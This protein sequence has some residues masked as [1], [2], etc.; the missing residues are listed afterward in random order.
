MQRI[1]FFFLF[2]FLFLACRQVYQE[3]QGTIFRTTY[4]VK[5]Q[6]DTSLI[7]KI[8]AEL[9]AFD[10]SLNPFNPNSLLARVNRNEEVEIDQWFTI[11]FN[12][13]MEVS[14]Q[15]N[16]LF[17]VTAAPLINLWGFG[18][19]SYDEISPEIIDSIKTFVGF[20]KVRLEG[21]SVVK[22]D[23]RIMLN[24]S[25]IAKG[26]ACDVIAK[27]FEREGVKNYLVDIGGEIAAKGKNASGTCWKIGINEPEDEVT[28][29]R[30]AYKEIVLLCGKNGLA[31]SGN[32]R[33]YYIK[34]GKKFAHT[35]N[36]ITGYPVAQNI[37]STTIIAPDCMTADAYATAFMVMGID[38]ACSMAAQIPQIE[39]YIIYVEEDDSIGI[40]Y[41]KGMASKLA[42]LK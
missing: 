11:V 33:N 2:C 38:A 32:Y 29:M 25:A 20:R 28:Y 22:D 30:N 41:S 36:P 27:L 35:I 10:L 13:A 37:L 8:K 7:Q 15:S 9:A 1:I 21:R 14:E 34:D 24:F 12:R 5:Y 6:S 42:S 16:G 17:D 19:E 40:K 18:F 39:Y 4:Q 3:E 26:Y 23:P 31:T